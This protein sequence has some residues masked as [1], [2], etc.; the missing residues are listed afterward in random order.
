ME[1]ENRH[2]NPH[3]VRFSLLQL[4]HCSLEGHTRHDG[5]CSALE[6]GGTDELLISIV[7]FDIDYGIATLFQGS[8]LQRLNSREEI[9]VARFFI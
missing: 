5:A 1:K 3:L 9:P 7:A 8:F 2:H 4:D 6:F